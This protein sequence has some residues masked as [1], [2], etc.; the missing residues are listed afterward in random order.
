[1]GRFKSQEIHDLHGS[2]SSWH[3]SFSAI[4]KFA[5]TVKI[6]KIFFYCTITVFLVF[7]VIRFLTSVFFLEPVFPKNL[8]PT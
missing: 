8:Q 7:V 6:E 2:G 4:V 3:G 1:M 5:F